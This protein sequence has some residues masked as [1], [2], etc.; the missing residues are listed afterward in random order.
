MNPDQIEK[1]YRELPS[2]HRDRW[3][4]AEFARLAERRTRAE[5][6]FLPATEQSAVKLPRALE[7]NE[8]GGLA[9][10]F[11]VK[12]DA[13]MPTY[14]EP[15]AFKTTLANTHER[16]RV[17]VLYQHNEPLGRPTHIEE[18]QAGLLVIGK[19]S[20]TTL[21]RD[22][23]TMLRDDTLDEMSIGFDPVEYHFRED[24]SKELLRH[25]TE[26]R[27]WEFSPV[28]FG[29]NSGAHITEVNALGGAGMEAF[30][31]RLL[32]ALDQ[33]KAPRFDEKDPEQVRAEI[34]RLTRILPPPQIIQSSVSAEDLAEI[35]KLSQLARQN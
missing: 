27:L 29:A 25:V 19:V 30:F 9:S 28:T 5:T 18:T 23:M 32:R 33:H 13:W 3:A 26:T 10:A 4:Q 14:I 34:E 20:D 31:E 17:K 7:K 35:E 12:I 15:G 8:F 22:V 1:A 24:S 11:G 2:H 21:G 16:R 6:H